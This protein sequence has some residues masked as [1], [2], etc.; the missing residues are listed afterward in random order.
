MSKTEETH[1]RSN[2]DNDGAIM[3]ESNEDNDGAT[4]SKSNEDNDGANADVADICIQP[5]DIAQEVLN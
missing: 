1:E 2:E 3:S 4:V 5:V